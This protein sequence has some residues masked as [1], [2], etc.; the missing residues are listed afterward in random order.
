MKRV[1]LLLIGVALVAAACAQAVGPAAP[2]DPGALSADE[3]DGD[4]VLVSGVPTVDGAAITIS[5]DGSQI[6]GRAACNTYGGTA[7]IGNGTIAIPANGPDGTFFM[8]EMGCEPRI[9]S[10]EQAFVEAIFAVTTWS[11]ENGQLVLSGPTVTLVFDPVAPI[12]TSDLVGTEWVLQSLIDGEAATSVAGDEATLFLSENGTVLGST[13]CRTLT[14]TWIV[15]SG[16]VFFPEFSAEGECP[17]DLAEQD[18][19]VVAVLGDGFRP[20]IS[21]NR[22]EVTDAS[23]RGLIYV[24]R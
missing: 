13:G 16:E 20:E 4:W 7:D 6:G 19:L 1:A 9:Q 15:R 21:G 12:A 18:G 3:L 2:A 5:F 17:P 14:G 11:I 22:L 8:T 10:S 24:G 23:G